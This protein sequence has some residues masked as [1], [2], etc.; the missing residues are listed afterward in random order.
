MRLP[1]E[2]THWD[3]SWAPQLD[4]P[5]RLRWY[6]PMRL[7]NET[8][9]QNKVRSRL[10]PK[11]S[12]SITEICIGYTN[13]SL[14]TKGYSEIFVLKKVQELVRKFVKRINGA[15]MRIIIASAEYEIAMRFRLWIRIFRSEPLAVWKI[16]PPLYEIFVSS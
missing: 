4:Y 11:C 7:P 8:S 15:S 3:F 2:T 6:H 13:I 9:N 14:L 10:H 12:F 16:S 5:M 1:N